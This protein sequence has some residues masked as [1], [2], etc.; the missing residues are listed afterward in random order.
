M[1]PRIAPVRWTPPPVPPRARR[2][3]GPELFP[4]MRLVHLPGQGHEDVVDGEGRLVTG[5]YDGRILRV[6]P[7]T[8][9]AD[10][11]DPDR[12][13]RRRQ[14]VG[15]RPRGPA[16]PRRARQQPVEPPVSWA[17]HVPSFGPVSHR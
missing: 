14:P 6:D 16:E 2:K 10:A 1:K 5:L 9:E 12:A 8:E 11:D 3:T 13:D 7:E 15:Q 4:P 17:R